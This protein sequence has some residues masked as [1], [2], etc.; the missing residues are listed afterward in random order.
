[1]RRGQFISLVSLAVA[2]VGWPLAA[3]TQQTERVPRIGVL[4]PYLETDTE[5]QAPMAAF[6]D[7]LRRLGVTNAQIDE[8]W[9]GGDSGKLRAAAIDLIRLRSNVIV[10]R[11][12]A[13]MTVLLFE[14]RT[15]PVVFLVISDPVGDGFV[16]SHA[17]PA[18]QCHRVCGC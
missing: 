1:M 12:T 11:S 4:L 8:R 13:A 10:T 14:T 17:R 5:A 16:F 6:R 7:E 18:R 2:A 3:W 15:I 9:A